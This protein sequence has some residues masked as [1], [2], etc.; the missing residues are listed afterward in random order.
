MFGVSGLWK[1][2][3]LFRFPG[4][5]D[6]GYCKLPSQDFRGFPVFP[7]LQFSTF[8]L[9]V[10]RLCPAQAG[11]TRS[12]NG[13]TMVQNWCNNGSNMP[14]PKKNGPTKESWAVW[15]RFVQSLTTPANT[16]LQAHVSQ[17]GWSQSMLYDDTLASKRIYPGHIFK[18]NKPGWSTRLVVNEQ[19]M[20]TMFDALVSDW[21][22]R[23]LMVRRKFTKKDVEDASEMA[24]L[25]EA[26]FQ[27]AVRTTPLKPELLQDAFIGAFRQGGDLHL[28]L[29]LQGV[30]SEK[31]ERLNLESISIIKHL[32]LQ[33][34]A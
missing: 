5:C 23:P 4:F 14:P 33:H 25:V 7:G 11:C 18:H 17:H 10:S 32:L 3:N 9:G 15:H 30:L 13:P 6:S 19:S 27:E 12:K 16:K 29:E 2:P 22:A 20:G 24:A 21:Q 34:K 28:G 1:F 26:F 8:K 31:P